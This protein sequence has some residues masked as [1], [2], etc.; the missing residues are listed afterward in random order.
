[1][2][3]VTFVA[4]GTSLPELVTAVTAIRKGHADLLVGNIIGADILNVL[5]VIGA[6]ASA[7]PLKIEP[8]FFTF[9]LP[10]MMVVLLLL[11]FYGLSREDRFRRWHGVPL[12]AAYAAFVALAVWLGASGGN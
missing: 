1:M 3:A 11:R 6:S 5:F 12:L 4:L 7:T 10:T 8:L 9:L 2:M